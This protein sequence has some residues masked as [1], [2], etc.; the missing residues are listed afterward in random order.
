MTR[1]IVNAVGN[2]RNVSPRS[3]FSKPYLVLASSLFV[4]RVRVVDDDPPRRDA[5]R[6]DDR[7]ARALGFFPFTGMVVARV[8]RVETRRWELVKLARVLIATR[9]PLNE[10]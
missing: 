6:D 8:V 5:P 3:A 1:Q 7:V 2:Q 4:E 10:V 9:A